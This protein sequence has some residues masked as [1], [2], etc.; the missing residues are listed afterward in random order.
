MNVTL[1]PACGHPGP[2]RHPVSRITYGGRANIEAWGITDMTEGQHLQLRVG[3]GILR[4]TSDPALNP[5]WNSGAR[6]RSGTPHGAPLGPQVPY[7]IP[8][9]ERNPAWMSGSRP[10]SRILACATGKEFRTHH[11]SHDPAVGPAL[12]SCSRAGTRTPQC[13]PHGIPGPVR[14]E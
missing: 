11:D 5:T 14:H 9:H 7:G 12:K 8:G 3:L 4:H 13:I 10:G 6:S 2:A 1:N